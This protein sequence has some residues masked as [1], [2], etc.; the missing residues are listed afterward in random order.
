MKII[1]GVTGASG[2]IYAAS[3]L[4]VLAGMEHEV[5][6]I[7]SKAGKAVMAYECG[8]EPTSFSATVLHDDD[9]MFSDLASGSNTGD[10]MVVVPCSMNT[11]ACIANGLSGNL[12]QRAAGVILKERR[13][14]VV[15]PRETPV[16]L[17]YLDNMRKLVE[18][19][20]IL[21][22]ASPGFYHKPNDISGLVDHIT[23]KI[24]SAIDIQNRLFK[25]WSDPGK[26]MKEAHGDEG[27]R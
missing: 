19:G 10:C 12:L 17:I 16:N 24:L 15:V 2:S 25:K 14:L 26:T 23:G 1:V 3:L 5:H 11:L 27:D 21:L 4:K 9:N 7:F 8:L 20:A 13:R 6:L 18:A 22:P